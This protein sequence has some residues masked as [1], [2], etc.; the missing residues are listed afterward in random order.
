MT[1]ANERTAML[2]FAR[3]GATGPN[4]AGLRCGGDIDPPLADLGR[5][6]AA[7]LAQALRARAEPPDLIVTSDLRRTRETAD[8]VRAV[9]RDVDLLVRPALRERRLGAWNLQ[10]I[11]ATEGWLAGGQQPPGGESGEDFK[12]R[13]EA[14]LMALGPVLHR[15]VLLI[16]SKGVG[17]VLRTCAGLPPRQPLGNAELIELDVAGWVPA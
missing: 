13:I 7:A 17:R 6:Q 8:V 12:A 15:R 1:A 3:H 4:L 11:E 2:L 10:S 16:G 9:L 5:Q 14:A